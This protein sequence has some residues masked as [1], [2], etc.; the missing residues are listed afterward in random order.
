MD[1]NPFKFGTE[2]SGEDFCDREEEIAE[3]SQDIRNSTNVLL[4]SPRR[5]GKTSLIK[6]VLK[7]IVEEDFLT[8]YVDLFPAITKEKFIETY[9]GAVSKLATGSK[10]KVLSWIRKTIP[11]LVPKLTI[12]TGGFDLEF[13]FDKSQSYTPIYTDL[14]QVVHNQSLMLGKAAV[15]VFDEFQEINNYTD[16]EIERE[17][18]SAFQTHSNVSYIFMGSKRHIMQDIFEN[19]GRPFYRSAKYIPLGKISEEAFTPFV[20]SKFRTGNYDISS[21]TTVEILKL[22]ECHPY[23]TQ[24]LCYFLW[25]QE[26]DTREVS[27][28][29]IDFAL[30]R[31]L[32]I[33]N[34]SFINLWENLTQKQR[35]LLVA[36]AEY[37]PSSIFSK[38]FLQKHLLGTAS[39]IQ[40][41]VQGLMQREI[42]SKENGRFV[43]EDV[44]FKRWVLATFG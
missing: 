40:K 28:E 20:T 4:Y 18:R 34:Q 37:G 23:Y 36:I 21:E 13:E 17:M 8:V 39:S 1:V 15:V 3:L 7:N 24:Q 22:S 6:Q 11:K 35:Q 27:N 33:E 25:E 31:L 38:D 30:K 19:P 43:F 29:S 14:F 32:G 10:E 9:A 44:F 12:R 41:A 26:I 16:D 2:V 5:F 42:V